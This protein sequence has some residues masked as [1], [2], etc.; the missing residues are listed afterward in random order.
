MSS[1]SHS[2]YDYDSETPSI[3][4]DAS[5]F[6]RSAL[7]VQ[8]RF[9]AAR[10]QLERVDELDIGGRNFLPSL[11]S[12]D[13]KYFRLM[14]K[15]HL[16]ANK[17]RASL[18][19][20]LQSTIPYVKRSD[21]SLSVKIEEVRVMT[22]KIMKNSDVD[23]DE[24]DESLADI[25]DELQYLQR[26]LLKKADLVKSN[27]GSRSRKMD[28]VN[29]CKKKMK[30][31]IEAL[32]AFSEDIEWFDTCSSKIKNETGPLN[33]YL[34]NNPSIT[35]RVLVR[36]LTSLETPYLHAVKALDL[37]ILKTDDNEDRDY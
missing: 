4:E 32:D 31:L 5:D 21:G 9:T 3:L 23:S 18:I 14:T 35:E 34:R 25:E 19:T 2:D 37:Y 8:K 11:D 22:D 6:V 1:P 29:D 36:R 13:E 7:D 27:S 28:I 26:Q 30:A 12:S 10:R 17:L 20:V 16:W 33:A 24:F 15:S